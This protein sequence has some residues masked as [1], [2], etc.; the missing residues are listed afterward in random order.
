MQLVMVSGGSGAV[1]TCSAG[2]AEGADHPSHTRLFYIGAE[3]I[4]RIVSQSRDNKYSDKLMS[5]CQGLQETNPEMREVFTEAF[6]RLNRGE[7]PAA[8]LRDVFQLLEDGVY[9]VYL[10]DCYPTDGSGTFFWGAYNLMREVRGTA[11]KNRVIGDR[12]TYKPCFLVPST[13]L[14]MFAMKTKVGT[15]E[16]VKSRRVQGIAYHLSGMH[17]VLLKGHHGAVSAAEKGIAFRCVMIE[18]ITSPYFDPPA[19][20]PTPAPAPA[21]APAATAAAPAPAEGQPAENAAAAPK[22]VVTEG[23]TGFRSPSIK[24]PIEQLTS[25]MLKAIVEGRSEYKPDHYRTLL[26][27]LGTVRKK[28]VTNNVIPYSVREQCERMPDCEMM[29]STCAIDVLTDEQLGALLAG[30]TELNGS[31]IISQNLYT[32]IITACSYLQF[33]DTKRFADFVTA[34]LDK[35]ELSA[36]HEY[37]ARRAL[38]VSGNAKLYNF[39]KAA[40]EGGDIKY[41]KIRDAAAQYIADYEAEH[42]KAKK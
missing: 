24:V 4:I 18:K 28:T 5:M 21:P 10:T 40:A 34:I 26:K 23:I 33:K 38:N 30:D 9:A 8:A 12:R 3:P 15:D 27:K 6:N 1:G 16:A 22:A 19:P 32:S 39:F 42:A 13:P 36:T 11:E 25:D 14:N 41:E 17:A 2:M 20:A 29:E 37:I 7:S 31:V 35:P